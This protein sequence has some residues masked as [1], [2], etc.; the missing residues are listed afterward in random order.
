MNASVWL[1]AAAGML[2]GLSGVAAGG[3]A[4]DGQAR[5]EH[6]W[7]PRAFC[8]EH[9][10]TVRETGDP[11]IHVCCYAARKSCVAVNQRSRTSVRVTRPDRFDDAPPPEEGGGGSSAADSREVVAQQAL[12]ASGRG[13][14]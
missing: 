12:A 2:L 14:P 1:G 13:A 6:A 5:H 4:V 11:D 8:V 9:G 7:S 3:S 10:G